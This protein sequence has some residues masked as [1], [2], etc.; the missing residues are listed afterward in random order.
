MGQTRCRYIVDRLYN[1]KNTGKPD[2]SMN[3]TL[4]N[5]LRKECPP[6]T[7]KGQS[8][9]LVYLNPETGSSYRFSESYYS[10]VK[11]HEAVLGVDQQLS[12]GDNNTLQIVDEFAAG[13]EDFRKALALSMSRMG[14]INVLTGNQGEIRRNCRCT[15]ADTNCKR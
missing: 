14:S 7:R 10:R 8:D 5:R 3:T 6:R 9:P 12:N 2:P 4:L 1:Y 13:F 11:T 15:N